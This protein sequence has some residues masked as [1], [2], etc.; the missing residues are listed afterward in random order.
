[1]KDTFFK[2]IGQKVQGIGIWDKS[3]WER[4]ISFYLHITIFIISFTII[5][6]QFQ[7]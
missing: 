1:M 6:N 7:F 5:G 4:V 2:L 3:Y